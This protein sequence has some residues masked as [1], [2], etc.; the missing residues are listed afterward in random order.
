[1]DP[2]RPAVPP[3]PPRPQ[4]VPDAVRTRAPGPRR[5]AA[6]GIDAV[7]LLAVLAC[8]GLAASLGAVQAWSPT[9]APRI[10][11]AGGADGAR[12][13]P[14]A[15]LVVGSD[16][17]AVPVRDYQRV[18]SLAPAADQMLAALQVTD[19]V[20]A[21]TAYSRSIPHVASALR[22]VPGSIAAGAGLESLVAWQPD[23]V[24]SA[25][26]SASGR[27]RQLRALGIPVLD[28]GAMQSPDETFQAL[29]RI[30]TALQVQARGERL[31]AAVRAELARLTT[32]QAAPPL[33][34][35]YLTAAAGRLE[36]G[37]AGSSGHDLLVAA[38]CGDCA[39]AAGWQG[40]PAL[41]VEDIVRLHPD[42]IVTMA[43]Q[44]AAVRQALAAGG[45]RLA[46][47]RVVG[48]DGDYLSIGGL[49]LLAAAELLR[50]ALAETP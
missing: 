38:G 29:G 40:W 11:G 44:E 28:L 34:A 24:L 9:G 33:R 42:C 13:E 35:C 12:R 41:G 48:V 50:A 47:V 30:A 6:A 14:G 15:R 16:G 7:N 37:A 19:R 31:A 17:L 3:N 18:I 4:R 1:M 49:D 43:G 26:L 2:S 23:L 39:A 45:A 21:V 20:L 5:R 27:S 8:L 46:G 36:C 22:A 25:D 32:A 10:D